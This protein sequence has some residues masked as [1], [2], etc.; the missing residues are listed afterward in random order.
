MR[1]TSK[2]WRLF[3]SILTAPYST[4]SI[5][6]PTTARL[7]INPI[8]AVVLEPIT[9]ELRYTPSIDTVISDIAD[10]YRERAGAIIF[11]GMCDD[12][13]KGCLHMSANKGQVWIQDA[14]SCVISAMSEN[15]AREVPVNYIGSPEKLAEQL[16]SHYK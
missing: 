4:W 12:G 13:V 3:T 5:V 16:I 9:E 11:S 15:V 1:E 6:T 2:L 14:E 10:Y 7:K 8:G